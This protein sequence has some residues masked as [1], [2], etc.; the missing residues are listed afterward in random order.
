MVNSCKHRKH[1]LEVKRL[2]ENKREA[3]LIIS[4][5]DPDSTTLML[6]P[7]LFYDEAQFKPSYVAYLPKL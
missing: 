7:I 1:E 3:N 4:R 6:L 5:R 2:F